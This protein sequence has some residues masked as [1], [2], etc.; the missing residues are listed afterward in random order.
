[1]GLR[2]VLVE[3]NCLEIVDNL[4]SLGMMEWGDEEIMK[5]IEWMLGRDWEI[6][7]Y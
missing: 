4:A 6:E 5:E 3:T 1:M 7:V 2:H